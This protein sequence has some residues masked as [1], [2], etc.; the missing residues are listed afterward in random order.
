MKYEVTS[1]GILL[2]EPDLDLAQTL[3]CGQAFR[4][5]KQNDGSFCGHFVDRPLKISGENGKFL[6]HDVTEADFLNVWKSYFDL[7]TDYSALKNSYS[8]DAPLKEACLHSGGIRLLRQDAWET[9]VS[10]IFSQNNNIPRIKGIIARLVEHYGH[11]PTANELCDE[12]VESLSYLRCGFRA[13]YILDAAKK[14]ASGEV[15]FDICRNAPFD[16][17]KAELIKILGVGPKVA[18]C[19]LLYGFYR[20]EAFPIDV[21]IKRVLEVYYPNGFPK[22]IY[23]TGG[24]AQLYLFN[25]IRHTKAGEF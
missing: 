12:T 11:F 19:A 3:D 14:V 25:Y 7:D 2:F 23:Q 6:L 22:Q 9:L 5:E 8:F 15:S 10:F 20:T 17:A 13:K 1:E 16:Q 24:I 18:D 21:W 4:W